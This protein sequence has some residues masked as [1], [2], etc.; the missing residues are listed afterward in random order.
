MTNGWIRPLRKDAWHLIPG[1][2]HIHEFMS[3]QAATVGGLAL[4]AFIAVG[5]SNTVILVTLGLTVTGILI[6]IL[7]EQPELE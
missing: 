6:G 3:V 5:F 7:T 4:T 2:R 1:W